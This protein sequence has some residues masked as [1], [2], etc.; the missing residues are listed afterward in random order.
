MAPLI[1]CPKCQHRSVRSLIRPR[2]SCPRCGHAIHSN[3]RTLS[4]I[5]WLAGG[6]LMLL[7]A[8]ALE[9]LPWFSGWSF[10][11]IAA[12]LFIPACVVHYVVLRIFLALSP[13]P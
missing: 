7:T 13:A 5:E 8:A 1:A 12:V 9:R 3:L 10:G 11:A 2:Y 6:P 4:F